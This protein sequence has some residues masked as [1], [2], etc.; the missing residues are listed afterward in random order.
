CSSRRRSGCSR[1]AR[2]A[3]SIRRDAE[4]SA[5]HAAQA[6]RCPGVLRGLFP[7]PYAIACAHADG[8]C[9]NRKIRIRLL[10]AAVVVSIPLSSELTAQ[11]AGLVADIHPGFAYNNGS[12][13]VALTQ[14]NNS[15][16]FSAPV[17]SRSALWVTDGTAIGT[18]PVS[19]QP[20]DSMAASV[21]ALLFL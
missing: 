6:R 14:V 4:V 21:G 7:A 18:H 19:M 10:A 11:P 8:V 1:P 2:P 9:M 3:R 13:P 5:A 16:Y 12:S 20:P 15:V 17:N